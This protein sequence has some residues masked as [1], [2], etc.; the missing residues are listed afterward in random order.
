MEAD[1]LIADSDPV[2]VYNIDTYI[3]EGTIR[4]EDITGDGWIPVFR[5]SGD[6]WSFVRLDD[7]GNAVEVVEKTRIS[8]LATVGL[9]YFNA[10]SAFKQ[11]YH[12]TH[13]EVIEKY[14]ETYICPL[15]QYC[16][17]RE[18]SVR[19]TEIEPALIHVL[20]TPDDVVDFYPGFA[21]EHGL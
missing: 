8:D 2:V 6:Q 20:G 15:Y 5:A 4:Q 7:D 10:W 13:D 21:D 3:E 12:D 1:P 19:V 18:D 16:I 9:Y 11:S 17:D 14:G